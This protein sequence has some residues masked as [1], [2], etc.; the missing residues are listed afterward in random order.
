M[1]KF[2]PR[3]WRNI[4]KLKESGRSSV[5]YLPQYSQW[6]IKWYG[7]F[8][9]RNFE[10]FYYRH[11]SCTRKNRTLLLNWVCKCYLSGLCPD[12]HQW[13]IHK[14]KTF[15]KTDLY[16]GFYNV[17]LFPRKTP[18]K[19]IGNEIVDSSKTRSNKHRQRARNCLFLCIILVLW[20][21]ITHYSLYRSVQIS[22]VP[23]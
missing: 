7:T 10:H 20:M 13:E 4:A 15:N 14:R 17:Q 1:E 9:M 12:V 22:R 18:P 21:E 8:K 3:P 19:Q 23:P 16:W 6:S 2:K 11:Y 5:S